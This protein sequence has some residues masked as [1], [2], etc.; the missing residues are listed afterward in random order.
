[1]AQ[2][3]LRQRKIF[4]LI[5]CLSGLFAALYLSFVVVNNMLAGIPLEGELAFAAGVAVIGFVYA[6]WYL[7]VWSRAVSESASPATPPEP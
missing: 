5:R 1:M 2:P 7:R 4:A 3:T 6:A